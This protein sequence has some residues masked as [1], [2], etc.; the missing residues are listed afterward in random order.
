MPIHVSL[1]FHFG[2]G[3][4]AA[5]QVSSAAGGVDDDAVIGDHDEERFAIT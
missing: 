1:F 2:S 4:A 3:S 5:V